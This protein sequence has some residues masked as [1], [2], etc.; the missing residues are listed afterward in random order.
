MSTAFESPGK[1]PNINRF[2]PN[3]KSRN[4]SFYRKQN[5]TENDKTLASRLIHT[6]LTPQELTKWRRLAST[7]KST[8]SLLKLNWLTN[9]RFVILALGGFR[10][11]VLCGSEN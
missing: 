6:L 4:S 1:A 3:L 8:P 11:T 2:N 7:K 5:V 10:V 9:Y